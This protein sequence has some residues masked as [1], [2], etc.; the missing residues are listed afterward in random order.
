MAYFNGIGAS[1]AGNAAAYTSALFRDT[2]YVNTLARFNPHPY[3]AAISLNGDANARTRAINAGLPVNFLVANPDLLGGALIVENRERTLYHSLALEFKRRAATGL[4]FATSYVMGKATESQFLSLRFDDP[5]VRNSGAEGDTT[6]A[7]KANVVYPLPFGRGQRFASGVNGVVDRVIGGWQ[8]ALNARLQS[9]RLLDF[10]NVRLVGMDKKELQ[11]MFKLRIDNEQRVYML[12]QDIIDESVKAFSV[13]ATSATGYG[14]LGPPSGRYI[15][16]ADTFDC[17][18]SVRGEGKCGLQSLVLPGPMFKQFDFSIVKRVDIIGRVNAEFRLDALNIFDQVNFA[19]VTG[20]TTSTD[21]LN[22]N[23]NRSNGAAP[24]SYE[25][26]GFA[27]GTSTT[28]GTARVLQIV[29][30]IRW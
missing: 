10:G 20:M 25:V 6:H 30:R 3:Q 15:A 22:A 27:V 21:Q 4:S 7:F 1:G 8:V 9:G 24:A 2:T 26:T 18:E 14:T 28:P 19:P 17:I 29:S 5:M 13:S 23:W 11:K 16:P 12:P